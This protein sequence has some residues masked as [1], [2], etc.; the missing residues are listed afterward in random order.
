MRFTRL[1][2]AARRS[3]NDQGLRGLASKAR[4]Y[5]SLAPFITRKD[6]SAQQLMDHYFKSDALK[7]V[8]MSILADFFTSP[9]QFIGLGLFALN[10]ETS[11]DK[12][13][14]KLLKKDAEQLYYYSILGGI[15]TLVDALVAKIIHLNGQICTNCTVE[16]ITVEDNRV[17]GVVEQGQGFVPYDAILA[18]GGAKE[19]FFKLVGE[20]YLSEEFRKIVRELPLM[21]SV[22]MLHLGLDYNPYPS[23]HGVCTYY[24]GTYDL[25]GAIDE[26]RG[27]V[28]HGGKDGFVVHVPSLHSPDMAPPGQHAMTIY[29]I[30]PD[31]L[32]DSSWQE[33]K[34][35]YADCMLDYAERVIPG[36]RQHIRV[37]E[38]ITPDDFRLR[39]HLDQH[40]FGGIA[41][42]MGAPRVP[43]QSPI[44]GLW[45]IGA[46]SE[47]GGG[48]NNVIPAAY[49]TAR[50]VAGVGSK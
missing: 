23:V 1:M 24:Y 9:S 15:S 14:P 45:F 4:L 30:C 35:I 33:M 20:A 43:H 37:L 42:V 46:Q 11:F 2:T 7:L 13:M 21:E 12:R 48:V 49:K 26:I 40:A 16:K 6:W 47:S 36:L 5:S 3:E 50:R 25:D 39:T 17:R 8:F 19:T 44:Q 28:Y 10:P 29:T 18:S 41:P 38:I 27:G 31:R 34:E 32:K 22:F